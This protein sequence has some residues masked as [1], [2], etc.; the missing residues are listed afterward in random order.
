[1][2]EGEGVF[3]DCMQDDD[4]TDWPWEMHR[5][6]ISKVGIIFAKNYVKNIQINIKINFK[7]MKI[8]KNLKK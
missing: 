4:G 2:C 1:M 7:R 5:Q 6:K 3:G 8:F